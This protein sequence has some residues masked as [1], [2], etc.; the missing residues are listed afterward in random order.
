MV[1]E[2]FGS[3]QGFVRF[4]FYG[5]LALLGTY[6][7]FSSEQPK[8]GQRLVFVCSGNICRSPL[9]E[10]YAQSLGWEA[11]SCG[12]NCGD[13]H[14]ADP[15]ARDFA[16]GQGMSLESHRTVNVRHFH[17]GDNDFV[18]VMEPSH[19]SS[20]QTKVGDDYPIALA[21]SYCKKRNPY[22]HDPYNCCDEFFNHCEHRVM[23][24]VRGLC[25]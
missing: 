25:G 15:R 13:D 22:I 9:A 16:L 18:V 3:R 5:C 24:A 23:E 6:R 17:F 11:A 4:F 8:R 10:V 19:T 20:F 1:Y 21:G 12:L 7:R 14:P 2:R